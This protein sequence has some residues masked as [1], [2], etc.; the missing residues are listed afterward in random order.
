[1]QMGYM[2]RL[3]LL[4]IVVF[5]GIQDTE[6]KGIRQELDSIM[7]TWYSLAKFSGTVLVAH[8]G[9]VILHKGYG[10]RDASLGDSCTQHTIYPIGGS[11]AMFTSALV[12]VLEMNGDLSI[13][14]KLSKYFPKYKHAEKITIN[15]L[16]THTSGIPDYLADEGF[17]KKGIFVSR[18]ANDVYDAFKD[19]DLLFQPGDSVNMSSTDYFLLGKIVEKVTDTTYYAS[20][21]KYVLDDLS[22][23]HSGFNFGGYASWD[24]AQGYTILNQF[25]MVPAIPLDST[26]SYAAGGLYTTT[27]GMYKL[28]QAILSGKLLAKERWE[29]MG[30]AKNGVYG[31][32]FYATDIFGRQAMGH[33]GE[34]S[35]FLSSFIVSPEDST[36]VI[37]LSNDAESEITY[38]QDCMLAA[39]YNEHYKLPEPKQP[40]FLERRVLEQYEGMYEMEGGYNIRI[41]V[42]DK[43]LWGEIQGQPEFTLLA[44]TIDKFYMS[45]VDVEFTFLREKGTN[46][47]KEVIMRQNRREYKGHKWQ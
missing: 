37:L 28:A 16:L 25:R 27:E 17:Y 4:L 19:K 35:G 24:K 29:E 14:D 1:M 39:L 47:V 22:I 41:F 8:H 43:L 36:I 45:T 15:D 9:E 6:A 7:N 20:L 10:I 26:V 40:V 46:L 38:A 32:G 23:E 3:F 12:N 11:T 34:T 18:K 42:K 44:E 13:E 33:M 21:R 5:S 31:M 30:I 2:K